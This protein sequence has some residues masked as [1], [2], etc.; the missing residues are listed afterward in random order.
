MSTETTARLVAAAPPDAV[1]AVTDRHG[2]VT[3]GRQHARLHAAAASL[4]AQGVRQGDRVHVSLP[5]GQE[6]LDVWF[7]TAHLGAILVPTN[8][9]STSDEFGHVLA[10][11]Q[12]RVSIADGE[13]AEKLRGHPVLT[14]GE[15]A[16]EGHV[17]AAP[18]TGGDPAAILYTSGTTSRPKGVVITHDNYTAVGRA[19][20]GQLAV[21]AADRWFIALPL[22]HA[23][24]QYYCTMSALVR[25]ASVAV[26]D[27][28]SA[29]RWGIQAARFGATLGSLFAAPI[30]MIL[31]NPPADGEARLRTV[32]F[33]QNLS[34]RQATE[35]EHR[36]ATRLVQLYGMTE[37]VL[38]PTMNPDT[39]QR[40]WNSIGRT[41]PGVTITLADDDGN[42]V[43]DG[44]AGEI[45]V[46]GRLGDT[47][48]NGYWHNPVATADTF[49]DG[50]LRTGDLARR[51]ADGFLYFVDRA[52]D[53]I[54]R[55]GENVSAGEIERVAGEHPA[56]AECAVVG[57]P[58][59]VYDEAVLLVAVVVPGA[60]ADAEDIIAWCAERL[61]AFKVPARVHFLSTLPRTSV[62][63][64]RKAD[65]RSLLN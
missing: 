2:V 18:V 46:H 27:R 34:D 40:R 21:T 10:D 11:A 28:F 43:P 30:R 31:T 44:E 54:K 26:A 48:A 59:P 19:V 9:N 62:G 52:K 14:P 37:T 53:M 3:Y 38:P 39:E 12:P 60:T 5:N 36:F 33:A 22:F 61:A 15:L 25:S 6:F 58:D 47:I 17:P 42:P 49:G 13:A 7:A 64:I 29:S 4:A 55:S 24:A 16:G 63:K 32:L 23:N 51:D 65:L 41:L 1:F 57:V 50:V 35:F 20:A 45:Q 56:I 8:P